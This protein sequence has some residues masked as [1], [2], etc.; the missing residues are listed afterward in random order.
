MLSK[1]L[2][3]TGTYEVLVESEQNII[4]KYLTVYENAGTSNAKK[5]Q[6]KHKKVR[7]RASEQCLLFYGI[8]NTRLE[9]SLPCVVLIT[10]SHFTSAN[11]GPLPLEGC[12]LQPDI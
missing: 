3:K 2:Q 12:E 6:G 5:M 10:L 7:G 1:P 8:L 11:F 4:P 9:C